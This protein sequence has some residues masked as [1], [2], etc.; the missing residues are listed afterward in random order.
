MR[1]CFRLWL[2]ERLDGAFAEA[3]EHVFATMN[4]TAL[5]AHWRDEVL[6]AVFQSTSAPDLLQQ[7]ANRLVSDVEL[8]RRAVHLLRV[9]CR[10]LPEGSAQTSTLEPDALVPNGLAWD[11]MPAIILRASQGLRVSDLIW[12]LAFVEDWAKGAIMRP[13]PPAAVDVARLCEL[14]LGNS[15]HI[16]DSYQES[17]RERVLNV[18]LS[19]PRA[20]NTALQAM[21]EQAIASTRRKGSE[22]RILDLI[23]SHFSGVAVARDLPEMTLRV[24]EHRLRLNQPNSSEEGDYPHRGSDTRGYAAFGLRHLSTYEHYRPASSWQGPFLNLL[25]HHPEQGVDLLIRFVNRCCTTYATPGQSDERA[26]E[27]TIERED[28]TVC[29]QWANG[30]LWCLYRATSITAS[31][32]S[33]I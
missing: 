8:L 15:R 23:W 19:I 4:N 32:A 25:K 31:R 14:L 10:R 5:P 12:I 11:A 33:R 2:L 17:Y 27:I 16:L 3:Q 13:D 20:S 9:A 1:R 29:R 26:F 24:V 21:I 7:L 28:G 6:V 22:Q 30:H 18:M